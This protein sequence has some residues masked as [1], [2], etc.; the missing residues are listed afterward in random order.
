MGNGKG[1]FFAPIIFFR[2]IV[3]FLTIFGWLKMIQ[4]EI[5]CCLRKNMK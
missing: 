2:I 5:K 3:N 1:T 4:E